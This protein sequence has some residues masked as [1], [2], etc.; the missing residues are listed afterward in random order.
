MLIGG[1]IVAVGLGLLLDNL[2]IIRFNDVWRF[3]PLALVVWGA[4]RLLE[5]RSMAG[6]VW[7]GLLILIGAIFLLDNFHIL[8]FEFDVF[9]LIW[10][11]LIIGFGVSMLLRSMDRKR[12]LEGVP[13]SGANDLGHFVLFSGL[14]RRVESQDFKGGDIV[15]IFGGVNIDLRRASI[16]SDRA[17]IDVNALFGGVDI[18]VPDNWRVSLKGMGVFGAFEDKTV[19]PKSDPNVKTPELVVTG[20]A[21]FGGVKVDN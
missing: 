10:P 3:W 15:A 2:G 18:R 5:S 8:I 21:L 20:A 11:L 9:E 1:V 14:K 4:S 19:P 7:G 6:Y 13:P 12:Y 16:A 17:V